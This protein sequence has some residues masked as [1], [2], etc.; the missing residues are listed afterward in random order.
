MHR[1]FEALHVFWYLYVDDI[2]LHWVK[3]WAFIMHSQR[4]AYMDLVKN[5]GGRQEIEEPQGM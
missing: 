3:F 2:R 1:I 4:E 5:G